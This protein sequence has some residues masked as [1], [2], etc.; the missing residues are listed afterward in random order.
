MGDVAADQIESQRV[1]AALLRQAREL[2]F[3]SAHAA[4]TEEV[5]RGGKRQFVDLDLLIVGRVRFLK[6]SDWE[7]GGNDNSRP[8]DE[9]VGDPNDKVADPATPG[10]TRAPPPSRRA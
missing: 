10:E 6:V 7:A 1:L 3:G 8:G 2:C 4:D 9:A 5:G